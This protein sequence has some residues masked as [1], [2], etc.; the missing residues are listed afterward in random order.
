MKSVMTRSLLF[1]A[2]VFVFFA[3]SCGENGNEQIDVPDHNGFEQMEEIDTGPIDRIIESFSSSIEMAAV[4]EDMEVPYSKN[5]IVPADAANNYDSNFKKAIGLGMF[6][7]DLGYLNV[8]HKTN[9]IVEYLTE[10]KR[11][12]DALDIDQFFDFQTLK[13]LATNSE[14]LDSLMF[15]SVDS[16]NK[17]SQHL[18]E[19]RRSDLSALMVTGVWVEGLFLACKVHNFK[20][21]TE[22]RDRIGGQK[23]ILPDVLNILNFFKKKPHFTKLIKEFDILKEAYE[24][25][26][27]TVEE[28]IT[29]EE[30][31][32]GIPTVIQGDSTVID[33]T[34]EQLLEISDLTIKIRNKLIS[35]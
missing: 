16:Y 23:T 32:D 11:L 35:L 6:S 12:S 15:L 21:T 25:V 5:Y 27:I 10:I 34:D 26:L 24:G 18:R 33:I 3:W 30:V 14:N 31:I 28:G 4:I 22:L 7:S 17:M 13:R 9:S 1:I 8:Y 29:K 2:I 20:P 19:T